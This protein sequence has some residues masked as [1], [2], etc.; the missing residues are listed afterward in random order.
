MLLQMVYPRFLHKIGDTNTSECNSDF[1]NMRN[2]KRSIAG[3]NTG[4]RK[5]LVSDCILWNLHWIDSIVAHLIATQTQIR[6]MSF[7]A[8]GK[9][10]P[11][12][13]TQF[14]QPG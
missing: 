2:W 10:I 7:S 3:R 8:Q 13:V 12:V 14:L 9:K 5:I 1:R 11:H 4:Y 6:L